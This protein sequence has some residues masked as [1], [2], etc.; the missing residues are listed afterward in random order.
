MFNNLKKRLVLNLGC[1]FVTIYQA[2]EK[3]IEFFVKALRGISEVNLIYWQRDLGRAVVFVL[4][5]TNKVERAMR[6]MLP[7]FKWDIIRSHEAIII[8]K[9]KDLDRN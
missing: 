1:H 4:G 5:N 2:D 9:E 7:M 6:E 8:F 3:V